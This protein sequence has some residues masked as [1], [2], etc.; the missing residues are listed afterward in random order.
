MST[1][2]AEPQIAVAHPRE[3]RRYRGI[4]EAERHCSMPIA[5]GACR[6]PG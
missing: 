5:A 2:K 1:R 3:T 6:M 4:P